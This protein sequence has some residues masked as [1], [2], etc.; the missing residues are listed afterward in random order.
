MC[1]EDDQ[2]HFAVDWMKQLDQPAHRTHLQRHDMKRPHLL[3]VKYCCAQLISHKK[4][5]IGV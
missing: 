4:H 3:S 2:I 5:K 1:V